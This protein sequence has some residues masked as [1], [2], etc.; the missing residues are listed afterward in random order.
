MSQVMLNRLQHEIEEIATENAKAKEAGRLW[1]E[2]LA[3]I[4][5]LRR[6]A[7]AALM[8]HVIDY[9]ECFSQY[10]DPSNA[11][12]LSVAESFWSDQLGT[13][14]PGVEQVRAFI[15]GA[16][17]KFQEVEA[18]LKQPTQEPSLVERLGL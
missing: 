7:S 5:Q 3:S 9:V 1:A 12:N 13:C 10:V 16:V 2:H 8:S 4:R 6:F 15:L 18:L 11:K 17:M 14:A